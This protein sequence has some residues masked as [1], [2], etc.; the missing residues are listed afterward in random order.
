MFSIRD[1]AVNSTGYSSIYVI[2]LFGVA[3][4]GE[5]D[6]DVTVSDN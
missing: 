1:S 6:M 2:K 5:L 3:P 4:R